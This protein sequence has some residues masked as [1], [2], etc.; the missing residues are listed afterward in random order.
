MERVA[1]DSADDPIIS[2]VRAVWEGIRGLAKSFEVTLLFTATEAVLAAGWARVA[3]VD[4]SVARE[5]PVLR[6]QKPLVALAD[7][8]GGA[9][10]SRVAEGTTA[11]PDGELAAGVSA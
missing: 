10:I 5:D 6:F 4:A 9:T 1:A 7:H 2:T 11:A 8:P 3:G